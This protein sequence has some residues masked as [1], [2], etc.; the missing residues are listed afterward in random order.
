MDVI[1]AAS[2]LMLGCDRFYNTLTCDYEQTCAYRPK[3][4]TV[5]DTNATVSSRLVVSALVRRRAR[6]PFLHWLQ[7][8]GAHV[9][10]IATGQD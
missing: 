3:R 2:S 4:Y 10:V 1:D 7:L 8:L 5:T 6:P 9:C